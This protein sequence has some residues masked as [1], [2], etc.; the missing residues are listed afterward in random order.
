M[1][2]LSK[3]AEQ[4][5]L[6]A[7]E[8]AA[9][10]VNNGMN[11]DDAISKSAADHGVPPGHLDLMVHAYNTGR[12]TT[13]RENSS[14]TLEKAADFA[15]ADIN[16]VR[17]VAFSPEQRTSGEIAN[18]SA[19]SFEYAVP[20]TSILKRAELARA[21]EELANRKENMVKA[22]QKCPTCQN[23]EPA[24]TAVA[25]LNKKD[26]YAE[27]RAA[28]RVVEESRREVLVKYHDIA[29]NFDELAAYF[30][31]AGHTPY[32]DVLENAKTLYGEQ[33]ALVLKKLAGLYPEI[34]KEA[35]TGSNFVQDSTPYTYVN[36]IIDGI[37]DYNKLAAEYYKKEAEVL[38]PAAKAVAQLTTRKRNVI[39]E[40]PD[41]QCDA[42]TYKI[43]ETTSEPPRLASNSILET[44]AVPE[45]AHKRSAAVPTAGSRRISDPTVL[46]MLK[47]NSEQLHNSL[48]EAHAQ[49]LAQE[50]A[51]REKAAAPVAGPDLDRFPEDKYTHRATERAVYHPGRKGFINATTY[52]YTLRPPEKPEEKKPMDLKLFSGGLKT[53]GGGLNWGTNAVKS[54]AEA[55]GGTSSKDGPKD[56]SLD[57]VTD[58]AHESALQ[59]IKARG[60]L[61]D[62][63]L[64]DD[65]I[66]AHDAEDIS[67]AF[68]DIASVSPSLVGNPALMRVMLRK[69]LEAGS[70][71]DFDVKQ[72]IEMDKLIADRDESVNRNRELVNKASG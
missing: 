29:S 48:M 38:Q 65:I 16:N 51:A 49:K 53:R 46:A 56:N 68:N 8:T 41:D 52:D 2:Q 11:P 67:E 10:Y 50:Q 36:K 62:L 32:A 57:T 66:S 34:E 33:A 27:K 6:S 60:V 1:N 21:R 45:V 55:I 25:A 3:T 26:V 18:R 61:N 70:L 14:S 15:L 35:A 19:V 4:K 63:V 9:T 7:I 12:T 22:A 30:K 39:L 72:L 24:D 54:V 28:A 64:N 44:T 58:P 31:T 13:Q 47:K 71:A 59:D 40:T 23:A 20:P 43:S 42:F 37:T 17:R 5:L 69:R